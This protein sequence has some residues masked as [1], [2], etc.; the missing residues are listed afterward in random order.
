MGGF[1]DV[2]LNYEVII[3]EVSWVGSIGINPSHLSCG[4]K[5]VFRSLTP[6]KVLYILLDFK[7]QF[8]MSSQD[9]VAVALRL[10]PPQDSGANQA[11]MTSDVDVGR[12]IH[13]VRGLRL[14]AVSL[15]GITKSYATC[16]LKTFPTSSISKSRF[17]NLDLV[18]SIFFIAFLS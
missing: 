13:I 8:L 1:D 14:K 5:N 9:K 16:S 17:C 7:V 12:F 6:E 10:E 4:Q 11:R 18:S 3:D 2:S 15:N